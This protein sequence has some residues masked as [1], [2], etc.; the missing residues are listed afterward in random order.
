MEAIFTNLG[1]TPIPI[2]STQKPGFLDP[3]NPDEPFTVGGSGYTVVTVGDNPSFK[4]ELK[5]AFANIAAVLERILFFWREREGRTDDGEELEL[6]V[7]VRIENKGPTDLRVILG[8][9]VNDEVLPS[10]QTR[11]FIAPEYIEIR[12]LGV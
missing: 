10:G 2:G 7:R 1:D 6:I 8:N 9:N 4:E 12:E 3:L 5:E 11:D